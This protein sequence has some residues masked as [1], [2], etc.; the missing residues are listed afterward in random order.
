M[1]LVDGTFLNRGFGGIAQD[2]RAFVSEFSKYGDSTLLLDKGNSENDMPHIFLTRKLRSLNKESLIRNRTIRNILWEGV[3]YQT[4]LTGLR[5][6]TLHHQTFLRIHDLFPVSNPEWFTFPGRRLFNIAL[7]SLPK[8]T[9][10]V[11]NSKT[12]EIRVKQNKILSNFETMVIHCKVFQNEL[13]LMPCGACEICKNP[14]KLEQYLL[15]VGTIEPR[16]NY[17]RL[18]QAWNQV[19]EKSNFKF[20]VI[21]GRT[22]WKSRQ[23]IRQMNNAKNVHHLTPCNYAMISLYKNCSAFIS[24]SLDEGFDMP[25]LEARAFGLLSALSNIDVHNELCPESEVFFSP[26]EVQDIARG[27]LQLEGSS[28]SNRLTDLQPSW[29]QHFQNLHER[30]LSETIH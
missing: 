12:T 26:L 24:A 20:L 28:G 8:S 17:E 6:P 10:L 14:T 11:C 15:A 23:I 5:T 30:I 18:V 13:E 19:G 4:H 1:L 29:S 25:S 7:N 3:F 27:I 22:G 21:V 16:K 9:V 2:N